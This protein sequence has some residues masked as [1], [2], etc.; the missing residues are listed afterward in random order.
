MKSEKKTSRTVRMDN[1][2]G[3]ND[4]TQS[5]MDEVMG[6]KHDNILMTPLS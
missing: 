2:A 6:D 4:P 5:G 3:Q 1:L